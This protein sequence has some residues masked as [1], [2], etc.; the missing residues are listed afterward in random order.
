MSETLRCSSSKVLVFCRQ[1]QCGK[2]IITTK[3]NVMDKR[4]R[5]AHT[6]YAAAILVKD[7]IIFAIQEKIAE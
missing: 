7:S 5:M 4:F 1:F 3:K 2:N 6:L